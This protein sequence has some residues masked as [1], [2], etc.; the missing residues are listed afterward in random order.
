MPRG[1]L[2]AAA[3]AVVL[4]S[5][6]VASAVQARDVKRCGITIG[7]GKTGTLVQDVEC[8]Y[9]CRNDATVACERDDRHGLDY[10]CPVDPGRGCDAETITLERNATLDLNGF[11]L[12]SAY[13]ED[14]IICARGSRS[15]CTVRGPGNFFARKG[16]AIT[17]NGRDVVLEDL[18][19]DRDY[20]GFTDARRIRA[21][22][23]VLQNCSSAMQA[24]GPVRLTDVTVGGGCGFISG[25]SMYLEDVTLVDHV[26]AAGT[27]R[28]RNVRQFKPSS[29]SVGGRDV[30]LGDS[31]LGQVFAARQL[32]LRDSS[33]ELIETGEEPALIRSSCMES[34]RA[35]G[36]GTWGVCALD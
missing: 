14:G 23:V 29:G 6:G 22:D 16:R 2:S 30:F 12:R 13:Q 35:D 27:V 8:G 5:L 3:V 9:R 20:R 10:R 36:S 25:S 4:A 33:V 28:G 7:A 19:I 34:E 21:R 18:T 11:D 17:P 24:D 31:E 26:G 32:V 1:R 15:K